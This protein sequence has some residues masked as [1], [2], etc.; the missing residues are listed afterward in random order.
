MKSMTLE[1]LKQVV[2]R[3]GKLEGWDFSR[4]RDGMDP[5]PW[6]YVDVIKQY[7]KPKD[8]V[9]DNG[10]GGGE[11]FLSLAPFFGEGVG[12]DFDPAMI[13]TAKRNQSSLSIDNVSLMTMNAD[14][15]QFNPA[16]FDVV[17]S[18]HVWVYTDQVLRVLRPSGYFIMQAVGNRGSQNFRD[19]F[20][21]W[22]ASDESE[23]YQS[24]AKVADE[25]RSHGCRI[26]A[27]GEYEVPYWFQDMDSFI[28]WLMWTPWAYPEEVEP[29]KHWQLI[30]RIVE[31]CQ[32]ERGI[33]TT[34]NRQL[35]IAQKR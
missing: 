9:L 2:E 10:T 11:I 3:V 21:W 7:L 25:F 34:V 1:E 26:I 29:E 14:N 22:K 27:L 15:L 28:F 18:R 16:E 24:A 31:T 35:M 33:E 6:N 32:T 4:V 30:N 20:G 23:Y 13:E 12:I 5:V 8:R 19:A 17:L